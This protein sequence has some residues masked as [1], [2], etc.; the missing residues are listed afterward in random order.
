M[1]QCSLDIID[2]RVGHSTTFKYIQPLLSGL[3][4]GEVF[5]Q[6]INIGTMLDTVA[7]CDEAS[8]GF[9]FRVAKTITQHAEEPVIAATEQNVTIEC[10]V[11]SVRDN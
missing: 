2:R 4:L 9:P 8:I 3:L 1:V 7:I 6:P 11:A 10:L 5:N